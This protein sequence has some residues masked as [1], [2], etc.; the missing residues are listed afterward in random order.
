[1]TRILFVC[2][3][4][5]CRSPMAKFTMR[6]LVRRAGM[7]DEVFVESAA[8][9]D[10]EAGN[11]IHPRAR[12][13]LRRRGIPLGEHAARQITAADY[14]RYDL[15]IGMDGANVGNMRRIWRGDPQGKVRLLLELAGET[16]DVADPWYTLDYET[17][18]DD[19]TR[20]CQALMDKL[21][22]WKQRKT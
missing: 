7:E 17:A 5:I 14:D 22:G 15:L 4:N 13:A 6:E 11:P 12:E 10:E 18:L 3:G 20:G 2:H 8:T 1:M 16:R 9:S 19:I 21:R